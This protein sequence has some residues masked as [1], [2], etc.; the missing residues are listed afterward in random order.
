MRR[1]KNAHVVLL[2]FVG[3]SHAC[4]FDPSF[5]VTC[6]DEA[7]IQDGR[8]CRNGIWINVAGSNAT[9][10]DAGPT[11]MPAPGDMA[12]PPDLPAPAD[13]SCTPESDDAFCARLAKDC[14]SVTD[15]DTCGAQRTVS[16]G[17]CT[18]SQTCGGAGEPNVCG[19]TPESDAELCQRFVKTCDEFEQTDNCGAV[20]IV[21]CGACTAPAVCGGGGTSNV[22]ACADQTDVEFCDDYGAVCGRLQELDLCNLVREVDC[23]SDVCDLPQTCGGGGVDNQCGC[24]PESAQDFCAGAGAQ[25]ESVTGSDS[26]GTMRTED[27]GTCAGPAEICINNLCFDD[28]DGDLVPDAMDNCPAVANPD[29]ADLDGDGLGDACDPDIDG[30]GVP[31][32]QD[33]NDF[34]PTVC[35]DVDGDTCDDCSSGTD[36]PANDGPDFDGDGLCDAGD[37]DIDGDG[38]PNAQDSND[39]DPTVCRDVDGD[40]CDDC[41]SGTDDPANDGPDSDSDGICDAGDSETTPDDCTDGL[42]NDGDGDIDCEDADCNGVRCNMGPPRFCNFATGTCER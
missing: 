33:S 32:A 39:F 40:T 16:C 9:T 31:N 22:C 11:D 8:E 23:G 41:S 13:A 35:R 42:D 37:P 26:C 10:S 1:S 5:D 30:D 28:T 15:V 38:V 14:D 18:G 24:I 36:D 2:L 4:S 7:A 19:C 27:C 25:C 34:D 6:D 29:Q 3:G 17:V 20:R 12:N 21:N